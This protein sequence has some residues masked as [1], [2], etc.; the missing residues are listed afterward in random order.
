M[1]KD[2]KTF[3][4]WLGFVDYALGSAKKMLGYHTASL[5]FLLKTRGLWALCEQSDRE[6]V[7][8]RQ[9]NVK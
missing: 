8:E 1:W 7:I 6:K 2:A 4:S 3:L 5:M 9:R